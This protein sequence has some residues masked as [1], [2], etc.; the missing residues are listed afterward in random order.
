MDTLHRHKS[1]ASIEKTHSRNK[2]PQDLVISEL[3][4]SKQ[5]MKIKTNYEIQKDFKDKGMQCK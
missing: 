3:P 4:G 5:I 1:K 2:E